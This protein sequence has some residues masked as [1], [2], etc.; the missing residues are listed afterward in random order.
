MRHQVNC[1]N[2]GMFDGTSDGI[3]QSNQFVSAVPDEENS[4][5]GKAVVAVDLHSGSPGNWPGSPSFVCSA[6]FDIIALS[7][8]KQFLRFEKASDCRAGSALVLGTHL[9]KLYA[10]GYPAEKLVIQSQ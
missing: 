7:A 6:T 1:V 5:S 4:I 9:L 8:Y 10:V 3:R 2:R